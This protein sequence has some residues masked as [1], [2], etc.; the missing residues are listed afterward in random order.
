MINNETYTC[1]QNSPTT[2]TP[3]HTEYFLLLLNPLLPMP[4]HKIYKKSQ[5]F[6]DE[7]G[8]ISLKERQLKTQQEFLKNQREDF[9]TEKEKAYKE[10]AQAAREIDELKKLS[11]LDKTELDALEKEFQERLGEV[12]EGMK[13]NK[14]EGVNKSQIDPKKSEYDLNRNKMLEKI[15]SAKSSK[16]TMKDMNSLEK[17]MTDN[18]TSKKKMKF[19]KS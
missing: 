10:I 7:R 17:K 6:G 12:E 19:R 5:N 11:G 1:Q 18:H 3:L 14:M 13:K 2:I 4:F 9:E 15:K 8:E 16:L